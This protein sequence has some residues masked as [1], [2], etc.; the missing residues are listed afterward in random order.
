MKIVT[1]QTRL[2][3]IERE[4]KAFISKVF[5]DSNSGWHKASPDQ[6]IEILNEHL[7]GSAKALLKAFMPYFTNN[8]YDKVIPSRATLAYEAKIS[9][10]SVKRYTKTLVALGI[11]SKE[12][13]RYRADGKKQ[14][15]NRYYIADYF[16]RPDV[17]HALKNMFRNIARILFN[18]ALL[19]SNTGSMKRDPVLIL[20]DFYFK[21]LLLHKRVTLTRA[22]ASGVVVKVTNRKGESV[23]AESLRVIEANRDK[24]P[25]TLRGQLKLACY[26]VVV[27]NYVVKQRLKLNADNLM[28]FILGIA[29][30]QCDNLGLPDADFGP[31]LVQQQE[32][33][34]AAQPYIDFDALEAL[35]TKPQ[36]RDGAKYSGN[37]TASVGVGAKP[38]ELED[39]R[40]EWT[41]E[42]RSACKQAIVDLYETHHHPTMYTS[43]QEI[44]RYK[45]V[46]EKYPANKSV[47]EP[48]R[49]LTKDA[50]TAMNKWAPKLL[51]RGIN[52]EGLA[53][54]Q[55]DK[56]MRDMCFCC[57]VTGFRGNN[58]P[59]TAEK[60]YAPAKP[61]I[62][63]QQEETKSNPPSGEFSMANLP[64]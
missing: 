23:N 5:S 44:E 2:S 7:E 24:L 18:T 3:R 9:D 45:V 58:I 16:L 50:I 29:R 21:P 62:M 36:Q 33:D 25:L 27:V 49:K 57:G 15:S 28:A 54:F 30:K 38:F 19:F 53:F 52:P 59:C 64:F 46:L 43:E 55:M 41:S 17:L 60:C 48:E 26:P 56:A 63:A 47:P 35:K 61:K 22:C 51:A 42:Q 12:E 31:F 39:N 32:L 14:Q 1:H 10:S 8:R 20:N 34:V 6:A 4:K 13:R 40:T 11:I 37:T